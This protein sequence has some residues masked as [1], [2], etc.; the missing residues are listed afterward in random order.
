MTACRAGS[1]ANESFVDALS[2]MAPSAGITQIRFRVGV[3]RHPLS[4]LTRELPV[5]H[6]SRW[7]E[8]L[9][10]RARM[11]LS[12][13]HVRRRHVTIDSVRNV[14]IRNVTIRNVTIRDITIRDITIRNI[15]IRNITIR[16]ITIWDIT[17]WDITIWRRV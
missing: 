4:P 10:H 13:T 9:S 1:T 6:H 11:G 7:H 16:N 17:I 8:G 3:G 5:T 14:T 2:P 12:W 15:T